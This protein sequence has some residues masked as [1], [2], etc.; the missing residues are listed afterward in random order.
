[1]SVERFGRYTVEVSNA[2]KVLFPDCGITKAGLI[3]YYRS[4]AETL[5]PHATGRPLTLHRFPD[6]IEEDGFYQQQRS[7]YFPDWLGTRKTPRAGDDG[8]SVE[9]VL[10][11]NQA[12][13]VYLANQAAISLHGWL[14]RV[15][16]IARPD[17]LIFDL[18]PADGSF[19]MVRRAARQVAGLMQELGLSAYA[20]TTGSRGLHVI[21]PLRPSAGFDA[22][23]ELAQGMAEILAARHPRQLTVEQRK[24]KR[25]GRIYLDIMR[26]AYGQTAVLPYSVR[27]RPGA[28]VATPIDLD[29]LGDA[30][31]DPQRWHLKNILRRLGQKGDSWSGIGRHAASP[32]RTHDALQALR[33]AE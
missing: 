12:S 33:D 2:D 8:E 1:M 13:L 9:H 17:R 15:P 6:G 19:A 29:E 18:D 21:T 16:R 14:S 26:N 4:V 30:R 32:E 3:D 25:E 27:A 22:V 10:C 11:N 24:D 7:D 20:M 23:R 28:P 31:L 5:L